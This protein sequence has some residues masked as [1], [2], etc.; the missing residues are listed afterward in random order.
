MRIIAKKDGKT[1]FEGELVELL[2]NAFECGNGVDS[3]CE[4]QDFFEYA[5]CEF[6]VSQ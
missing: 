5:G 3:G 1:L 6:E 2:K 4:Y